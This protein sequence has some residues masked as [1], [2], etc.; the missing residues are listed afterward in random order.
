MPRHPYLGSLALTLVSFALSAQGVAPKDSASKDLEDQLM[1]LLNTPITTA[2]KRAERAIEAPSVVSVIN[3]DQ[4]NAYGWSSLNEVLYSLPGFG[5]AQDYDRRT[6]SSRGLFEGWNNNHILMLVDGIPM[7][8][9]IYGSA[10]TWE[11]TPLFMAKTVEVVRGPGSALYGSNATNS[12]VQVKSISAKDIGKVELQ[13]RTGSQG[14]RVFD[15]LAGGSGE[16][17]SAVVGFNSTRS[18]GNRHLDY[19]GSL[20]TDLQGNL[21]KF[22]VDETRDSQYAWAK[23]EGESYLKGWSLQV[24]EQDWAYKTGHGWLW[25]TPDKG[26]QLQEKRH[27]L[28]LSYTGPLNSVWSQEYLLRYQRHDIAWNI[29]FYPDNG[30]G[31][32]Y[33]NGVYETLETKAEDVFGRAQFAYDMAEG[34][35]L[36]LGIE[37]TRFTYTGDHAHQSN[38]EMVGFSPNPGDQTQA[39]GPWLE[40]LKDQPILNTGF[41]A[42]FSSGKLLGSTFK[43]V[44]GLRTDRTAFDYTKIGAPNRPTASKSYSQTS[45]RVALVFTPSP[46][47]AFKAMVGKAFR[48]P[49]P[50]EL[51][52]A[53]T[54]TLASNIDQL[55]PETLT[56]AELAVDWIINGN[57]NWRTNIYQ[58]KFSDQI[59]YSAANFNLSTNV[60]TLTTQGLETELLYG[61]GGWRGYANY[62]FAKRVDED[63]LDSTITPSKD[64]LT[65]EPAHRFK[66]GVIYSNEHISAALSGQYQGQVDRRLSDV[67]LQTVPLSGGT[68]DIDRYRPRNLEAWFTLDAKVGWFFTPNI[69]LA[70]KGTNLLD[71]NKNKLIKI[72]AFP[73]DYQG[74]GR[75]LSLIF[76]A[77]F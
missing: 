21:A 15:V 27:I 1:A 28:A 6:V 77:V 37:G 54:L 64:K 29:R 36:L 72:Q 50:S 42:Q 65:W 17:V 38:I 23:L 63:V 2:S 22:W 61:V 16:T 68:L 40:Y 3:R 9:N 67:G 10:Y 59:A 18:N 57:L 53:N 34:A 51:A 12:V 48:S 47:L 55:K 52:G 66:L 71:T 26:E 62:S 43:A 31:G 32:F 44:V 75:K 25:Q 11:I 74:E 35:S 69:S 39:L 14:E 49:A 45:P 4:I 70:V 46:N 56:T 20:R 24:H 8:D 73:F 7:N 33:P 19:D 60:Y 30:F 41:Y 76:K 13:L 58:T 5:P